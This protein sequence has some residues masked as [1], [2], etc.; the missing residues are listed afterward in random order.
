VKPAWGDPGTFDR[1]VQDYSASPD[2][3]RSVPRT[4][5]AYRLVIERLLWDE[6]IGHRLVSLMTPLPMNVATLDLHMPVI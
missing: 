2:F 6:K 1:L 3:L 4:Q 5:R